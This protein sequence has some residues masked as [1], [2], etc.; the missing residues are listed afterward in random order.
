MTDTLLRSLRERMLDESEP[1]AGL[2]RKCLLLGAE[3]GSA[4]LRDWARRELKGYGD[5]EVVPEYRNIADVPISVDSVSGNA[6]MTGQIISR[7]QMPREVWEYVPETMSFKQPVEELEQMA[8][9]KSLSFSSPGLSVAQTIW[10]QQLGPF[11]SINGLAFKM[12]GSVIAG[13][14]G[15][16]R[17]QLVDIIADLTADT[18]MSELPSKGQVDTAVTERIGASTIYNTTVNASGSPV[19]IG[20]EAKAKV[21]GLSIE[22]VLQLLDGVQLAATGD[23]EEADRA[24]IMQTVTDLR[25]MLS[26]ESPDTGEVV[27]RAG[28]LR[29][30]GARIGGTSLLAATEGAASAL[31][32]MAMNG[33]FG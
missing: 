21:E 27:K 29:S 12:T 15:Q 11:Q 20:T 5:E 30:L 26:Q 16:V 13:M 8:V 14:V 23:A 17:T 31:V 33:V 3:T 6:W 18:P 22:E 25:T 2:L 28:R 32:E 10:N 19:A 1:L 7:F 9:Q 24:A 4:A